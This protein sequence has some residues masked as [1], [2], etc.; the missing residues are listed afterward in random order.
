[1][2]V[3]TDLER[4]DRCGSEVE[5]KNGKK[6]FSEPGCQRYRGGTWRHCGVSPI[7]LDRWEA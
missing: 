3:H 1:M 6:L 7:C 4:S 2:M 5:Q